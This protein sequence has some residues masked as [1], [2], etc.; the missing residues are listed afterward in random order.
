LR[1]KLGPLSDPESYF[2]GSREPGEKMFAC[3]WLIHFEDLWET[4]GMLKH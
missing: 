4:E 2:I 3:L 1:R